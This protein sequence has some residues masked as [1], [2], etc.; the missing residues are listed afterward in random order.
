MPRRTPQPE[1]SQPAQTVQAAQGCLPRRR[2]VLCPQVVVLN[3]VLSSDA[4]TGYEDFSSFQA[5]HR[6][7][8]LR[9]A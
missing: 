9:R 4:T 3:R 1:P 7:L 8:P 6:P 5:S 2:A